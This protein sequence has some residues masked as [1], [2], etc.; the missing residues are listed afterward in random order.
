[1]RFIMLAT[2]FGLSNFR[3]SRS[4]MRTSCVSIVLVLGMAA[5]ICNAQD[6]SC[7]EA[8]IE[9]LV[10]AGA[11]VKRFEVRETETAGLLVRLKAHHLDDLGRIDPQ[12]LRTL[13]RLPQ[14]TVELRGIPLSDDGL[15]QLVALTSLLGLDVSGSQVTDAGLR[16]L[17]IRQCRLRLLDLSFTRVGDAGLPSLCCLPD[18]RH[19]SLIET[20]ITDRGV[21]TLRQCVALRELYIARTAITAKT[22]AELRGHLPRCRIE[23]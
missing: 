5:Q 21:H 8:A 13:R 1:M 22:V 2:S 20:R 19:L 23:P 14:L 12:I 7:T 15:S 17:A 18:L 6:D 4:G 11:V 9:E 16:D 10:R 3:A